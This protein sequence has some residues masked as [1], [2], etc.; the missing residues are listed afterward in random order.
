MD[1]N[2]V[3][4]LALLCDETYV[5]T[6][7]DGL[8]EVIGVIISVPYVINA[9]DL[10]KL[11]MSELIDNCMD[12]IKFYIENHPEFIS[13]AYKGEMEVIKKGKMLVVYNPD[14]DVLCFSELLDNL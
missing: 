8:D 5:P 13:Q 7:T 12:T 4:F 3:S 10:T 14:L 9:D 2:D 6:I 1:I 11:S